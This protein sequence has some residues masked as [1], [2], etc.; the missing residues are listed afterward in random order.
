GK[1]SRLVEDKRYDSVSQFIDAAIENQLHLESV[2]PIDGTGRIDDSLSR[3][4]GIQVERSGRT[5]S[6][7]APADTTSVTGIDDPEASMLGS[8]HFSMMT[9]RFLPI[10]V[11]LRSIE[12]Y[13]A[14]NPSSKGWA[15]L[16]IV[17]DAVMAEAIK[18]E[19]FLESADKRRGSGEK[20]AT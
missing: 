18:T 1:M 20:L 14:S 6:I 4:F 11:A 3:S 17:S 12:S 19:K 5:E 16:K 10:K 7:A 8:D 9:N 13:L 2:S 15:N